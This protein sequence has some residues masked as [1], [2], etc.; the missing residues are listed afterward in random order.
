MRIERVA[1]PDTATWR[2]AGKELRGAGHRLGALLVQGAGTRRLLALWMDDQARSAIVLEAPVPDDG[3]YPAL[4]SDL[5]EAQAFERDLWERSGVEPV[6]HPWLKALRGHDEIDPAA[7]PHPFF[8]IEGAG[9]HEVA[10]GPVHAGIIE[11]GHF[12]F[13]CRGEVVLHLEIQL[14]YQHRGALGLLVGATPARRLAVAETIAGDTSVGHATAYA[15]AIESLARRPAPPRAHAIRVVALE[16]ERL[17]CHVGGLGALAG[18]VGYLPGASWLGRLRGDFLNL[19]MEIC[20]SRYGRGLVAPG[21]VRFDVT[22][23]MRRDV[24]R[25][26]ARASHDLDAIAALTLD[27]PTV[28]SRFEASGRLAR[29]DAEALGMVGPAARASGL[30]RDARR[31]HPTGAWANRSFTP[32]TLPEG[33]VLA[34]A[35]IRWLESKASIAI[36]RELLDELPEG[37]IFE[38]VPEAL[39]PDEDAVGVV[40]GWRGEIVHWI[41]TDDS[42][43]LASYEVVDPSMRN[44]I[45]LALAMRGRQ[46]SDFP[47]CNKSFDLSYAGHDL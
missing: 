13:Q 42:G 11:P 37:P 38:P 23:A 17:A 21:G 3:R 30:D 10:V 45:G 7:K 1:H 32:Q 5:P 24:V 4:S 35:R 27:A 39:G 46:I 25:R 26:L 15:E 18:D 44:W 43:R 36:V 12:R 6:G 28:R 20:G 16:L 34:R 9:V 31:D 19:T 47:L 22:D 8:R 40:E 41:A 33:D 29:A 2:A 14:G